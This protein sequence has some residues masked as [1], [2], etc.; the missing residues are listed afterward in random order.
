MERTCGR[1]QLDKRYLA[2]GA[3]VYTYGEYNSYQT[4]IY[5]GTQEVDT[6]EVTVEFQWLSNGCSCFR[7]HYS[8]GFAL[9][10]SVALSHGSHSCELWCAT[11]CLEV[12]D[13]VVDVDV[14]DRRVR[15]VDEPRRVMLLCVRVSSLLSMSVFVTI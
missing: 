3:E 7:C 9:E 14:E 6:S 12:R 2:G 4:T 13:V 8:I 10:L 5:G 11:F 15:G 1:W